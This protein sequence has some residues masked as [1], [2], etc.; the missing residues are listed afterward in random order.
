MGRTSSRV[1][2]RTGRI[3]SRLTVDGLRDGSRPATGVTVNDQL[4]DEVHDVIWPGRFR[5]V[6][7][8]AVRFHIPDRHVYQCHLL[9]GSC[10]QLCEPTRLSG[11]GATMVT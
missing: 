9:G 3:L 1:G 8:V 5:N 7:E 10:R 2:V 6:V 4:V 11:L